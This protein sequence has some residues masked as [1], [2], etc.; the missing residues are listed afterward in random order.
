[1]SLINEA[2]KKAQRQRSLDSAPL[3]SAPSGIAAAAVT[4][5]VRA[6]SHKRS[7][8]PLWFGLGLV[9]LGAIATG[10]V[11]HYG[12]DSAPAP[13]QADG[14]VK[15]AAVTPA[16]AA[17]T[18]PRFPPTQTSAAAQPAASV[19]MV[20]LPAIPVVKA[21]EAQA[22]PASVVTPVAAAQPAT[23]P[24]TA[25][26]ATAP[27]APVAAV[28]PASAVNLPKAVPPV[29]AEPAPVVPV[30]VVLTPAEREAKIYS[31]LTNLRLT[32]VR[33]LDRD[34][35]VLMNERVWRLND[36]VS[37]ELGLRLSAIRPNLLVFTD[38]QG[39]TFEKPY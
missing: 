10:L 16:P 8:A 18:P 27:A 29:P 23:A 19:P 14:P 12:F 33:G 38:A 2:L 15:T 35:R 13:T 22:A 20:V 36:I 1:M 3:S 26:T 37:A 9:T 17:T 34:A 30:A 7:H 32:G 4:T 6:A 5:H 31:F 11:M 39:K 24:S 21:S 25:P 28:M